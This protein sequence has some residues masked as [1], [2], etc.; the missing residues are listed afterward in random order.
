MSP[1]SP[2]TDARLLAPARQLTAPARPAADGV[3]RFPG[4]QRTR[5][6]QAVD[7]DVIDVEV[8]WEDL[9]EPPITATAPRPGRTFGAP[10]R[11]VDP[12][13]ALAAYRNAA[14]TANLPHTRI[15]LFA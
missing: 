7:P 5:E 3:S 8:L 1:V 11:L 6:P 4:P 12:G 14:T 15:D 10:L 9:E 2:A 13:A